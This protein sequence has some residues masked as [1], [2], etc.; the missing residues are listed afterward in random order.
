MQLF[1]AQHSLE[2]LIVTCGSLGA[3]ALNNAGECF[4]VAPTGNLPVVDTVGAGDAFSAVLLLG[5]QLDWSL[6][7]TMERAQTFASALVSQRGATVQDLSFYQTF[8]HAWNL[9]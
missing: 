7:V 8:I 9:I 2:V 3:L 4:E 6:P 5:M 1:L